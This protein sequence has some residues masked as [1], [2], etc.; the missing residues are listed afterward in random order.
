MS[1]RFP[2]RH[3]VPLALISDLKKY[4]I[5]LLKWYKKNKKDNTKRILKVEEAIKTLGG[6]GFK[7]S[8]LTAAEMIFYTR[9]QDFEKVKD[10][11][12]LLVF[13]NGVIDLDTEDM[14][15]RDGSP[16]DCAT[17]GTSTDYIAYDATCPTVKEIEEWMITV[18]PDQD[19]RHYLKKSLGYA[20]SRL[21]CEQFLFIW[22]GKGQN[23]KTY[24]QKLL[25]ETFQDD[26][27]DVGAHQLLTRKREDAGD[28]NSSLMR[29]VDK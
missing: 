4:F 15:L 23:G 7:G 27:C 24:L 10:Q 17:K 20:M 6:Q 9:H 11:R 3:L 13:G 1:F 16:D 8:T 14:T 22:T 29:L 25:N 28:T 21:T 2:V 5:K 12:N 18:Q 19:Q 26:Y